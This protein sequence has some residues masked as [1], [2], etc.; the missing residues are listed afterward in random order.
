MSSTASKMDTRKLTVTG[1]MCAIS[2][3]LCYYPEIPFLVFAPWTAFA[4]WLKLDFSFVPILL[5][6]YS[7]GIGEALTIL[8][9]KN[10]IRYLFF[11]TTQGV[12]EIADILIGVSLILPVFLCYQREKSKK[13]ALVGMAIGVLMMII[14]GIFANRFILFP[15]LLGEERFSE[16]I[17][18][19]PLFLWTLVAPFNLFKGVLVSLITFDLYKRLSRYLKRGLK[20]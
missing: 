6:C 13:G 12:G 14:V 7:L 17:G 15:F 2:V 8:L 4:P 11:T 16:F 20:V 9:L 3:V 18:Q 5:V 19:N 10:L 1:I